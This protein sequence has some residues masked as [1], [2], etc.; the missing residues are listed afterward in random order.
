MRALGE[1]IVVRPE[2]VEHEG[3]IIVEKEDVPVGIITAVGEDANIGLREEPDPAGDG[4]SERKWVVVSQAVQP[5]DRVLFRKYAGQQIKVNGE[6]LI[7]LNQ[8]DVLMVLD[9]DSKVE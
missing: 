3:R 4:D 2:Q 9:T 5:G 6:R 1:N 8:Q 7:V